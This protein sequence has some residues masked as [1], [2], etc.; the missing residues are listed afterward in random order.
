[1]I[2]D[3]LR[4]LARMFDLSGRNPEAERLLAEMREPGY[5]QRMIA[6]DWAVVQED[7]RRAAEVELDQQRQ[8]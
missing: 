5:D 1:M 7:L 3:I 8:A 6:S 2:K 4:G